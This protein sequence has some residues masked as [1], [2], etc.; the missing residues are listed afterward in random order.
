[1]MHRSGMGAFV[2]AADNSTYGALHRIKHWLA[3]PLN[4][5]NMG[6]GKRDVMSHG[7]GLSGLGQEPR[8]RIQITAGERIHY[9]QQPTYTGKLMSQL[10]CR[11]Q[12]ALHHNQKVW[13]N[14]AFN[15]LKPK[16][17]LWHD[18]SQSFCA[19]ATN[20]HNLGT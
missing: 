10:A 9:I 2:A 5:R 1:M 3:K 18:Y 14:V 13:S 20:S 8:K 15:Y 11:H 6:S 17:Q 16:P 19:F 7:S 4:H 12:P